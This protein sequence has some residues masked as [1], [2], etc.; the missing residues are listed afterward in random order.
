MKT[1]SIS[2]VLLF[3]TQN[4]HADETVSCPVK[5][6][7]TPNAC[8]QKLKTKK[9]QTKT[10]S[11]PTVVVTPTNPKIDQAQQST[12]QQDTEQNAEQNQNVTVV[13]NNPPPPP[14]R[15]VYRLKPSAKIVRYTLVNPNRLQLTLGVSHTAYSVKGIDCCSVSLARKHEFDIGLQYLRDIGRFT[16]SVM[17]TMNSNFYIGLGFNW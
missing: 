1:L 12:Q 4:A 8:V 6:K 15:V 17:A 5:K 9:S 13:I 7:N 11:S 10:Q 14:A 3:A 16:G 2:I